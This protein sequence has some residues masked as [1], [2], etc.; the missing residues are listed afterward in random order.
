MRNL[1]PVPRRRAAASR[2]AQARVDGTGAIPTAGPSR[3]FLSAVLAFVPV[4]AALVATQA[5]ARA[6]QPRVSLGA[7]GAFAVLAGSTVTNTGSSAVTGD[8][9][10][11]PGTSVTGFPPGTVAGTIHAADAA[12]AQAQADLTAAYDDAASR[13]PATTVPTE[14]GG[15]TLTPGAW[16]KSASFIEAFRRMAP[17]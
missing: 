4:M 1:L 12:A 3:L 13:T 10:L 5:G 15:T 6:P 2:P 14:L 11:S 8:L 7:A 9:G 17:V 16:V